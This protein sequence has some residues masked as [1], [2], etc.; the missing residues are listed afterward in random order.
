MSLF[1]VTIDTSEPF[2]R[3]SPLWVRHA[4]SLVFTVLCIMFISLLWRKLNLIPDPGLVLLLTV[5]LTT[6]ITGGMPGMLSS[7]IVLFASFI[8]F[9]HPMYLFR[10]N[11][12]DWR[13]VMAIAV[14][15]PMIA[16]M[17]GSLKDQVDKLGKVTADNEQLRLEIRRFEGLKE[18]YHL[19][20]QRFDIIAENVHEYAVFMLD[21]HGVVV[22]WNTGA[23]RLFGY[24]GKEIIGENF[25]RFF[26]RED[27][28][29]KVPEHLLVQTRFAGKVDK[30]DWN[31]RK[32]GKQMRVRIMGN[33]IKN[34]AGHPIGFL[35]IMRD[36]GNLIEKEKSDTE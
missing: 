22:K 10:Y 1:D 18:A 29:S 9:S 34:T 28:Y 32:D 17:V 35:M 5:A 13:Q 12:L 8:I 21:L 33:E 19:C 27:V 20:E 4:A 24:T 23:E 15:C 14:A 3:G 2:S 7:A 6:Y 16:L 31:V 36:L 26:S 11:E 30:T 25:N